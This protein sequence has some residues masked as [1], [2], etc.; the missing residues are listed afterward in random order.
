M[1]TVFSTGSSSN[2]SNETTPLLPPSPPG[3]KEFI[4]SDDPSYAPDGINEALHR[5]A[6]KATKLDLHKKSQLYPYVVILVVL[7]SLVGDMGGSLLDTPEVRLLEMAVCRDYYRVH[8]P[9][10][11]GPQPLSYIPEKYCKITVVQRDLAYLR[12]TKSLLMTLPGKNIFSGY[13]KP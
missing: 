3:S 4:S 2:A 1:T 13:V 8:D 9:N 11:I 6:P 12:A 10:V 7:L 5:P